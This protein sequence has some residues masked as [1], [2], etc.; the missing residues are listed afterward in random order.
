MNLI[1]YLTR[2]QLGAGYVRTPRGELLQTVRKEG[3]LKKKKKVEK[4]EER[5]GET[6][7][8]Q[9]YCMRIENVENA[10]ETEWQRDH[11]LTLQYFSFSSFTKT[12]LLLCLCYT[13]I[14]FA[15]AY[16]K[17]DTTKATKKN[18]SLQVLHVTIKGTEKQK[19]CMVLSLNYFCCHWYAWNLSPLVLDFIS[20]FLHILFLIYVL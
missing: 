18:R 2:N 19:K 16:C 1:D 15:C 8:W 13:L 6:S 12:P 10:G 4:H 7:L 11:I 17:Y 20:V 14:F 9:I 3:T 5:G